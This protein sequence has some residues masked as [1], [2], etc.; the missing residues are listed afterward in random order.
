[1]V[2]AGVGDTFYWDLL[3]CILPDRGVSLYQI[4]G[5]SPLVDSDTGKGLY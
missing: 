4:S 1:M 2:V 3:T 5:V